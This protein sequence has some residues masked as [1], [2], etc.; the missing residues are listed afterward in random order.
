ML[1]ESS[2]SFGMPDLTLLVRQIL[3]SET[4][5]LGESAVVGLDL[6]GDMLT[7]DER[8]AE[9]DKGVGRTRDMVFGLLFAM[10]GTTA[11]GAFGGGREK[12]GF[13]RCVYEGGGLIE[14][15]GSNIGSERNVLV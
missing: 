14:S 4:D 2:F 11:R 1:V 8:G 3:P 12:N 9:E 7:L 6:G 15:D 13:G 5:D 10:S